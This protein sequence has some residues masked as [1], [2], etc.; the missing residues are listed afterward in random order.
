MELRT[1]KPDAETPDAPTDT[2][3]VSSSLM[4]PPVQVHLVA[5]PLESWGLQRLVQ[6]AG[7]CFVL[8]GCS[9]SLID[10]LPILERRPPD[11]VVLDLDDGYG[12][13]DIARL[14]DT[15]RLKVLALSS[16]GETGF[17]H[18]A[19]DAGARGFLH[20]REAPAML[21]KGIEAVGAGQVFVSRLSTERLFV[22]AAQQAAQ[23][24]GRAPNAD[25]N[26][27]ATLTARELQTIAAVTADAAQPVKVIAGNMCISEHTLRNHLTSIYSK[28]GVSGRLALYAYANQHA[29]NRGAG[30]ARGRRV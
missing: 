19:L 28:L 7:A 12:A 11:V 6:T 30:A 13:S 8:V 14:Y 2:L 5:P 25:D 21:L 22:A 23:P 18:A 17:L 27:I 9:D 26:R 29:L 20:K 16:N 1:G 4:T 3:R 15:M 10:A 24:V